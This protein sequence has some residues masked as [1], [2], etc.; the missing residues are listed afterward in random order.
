MTLYDLT[1]SLT[2]QG[3]ISVIVTEDGRET[4]TRNFHDM[5]DFVC[6]LTDCDDIEDYEVTYIYPTHDFGVTWLN[7]EVEKE[8]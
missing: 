3:N 7:I 2:L 5:T 6:G 1:Q 8:C 4:E